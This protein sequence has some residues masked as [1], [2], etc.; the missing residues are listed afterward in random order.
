MRHSYLGDVFVGVN[1]FL[2]MQSNISKKTLNPGM[3]PTGGLTDV[4]SSGCLSKGPAA[5]T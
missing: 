4:G 2:E 3:S 5:H 1:S